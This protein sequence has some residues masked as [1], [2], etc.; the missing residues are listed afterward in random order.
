ME[1]AWFRINLALVLFLLSLDPFEIDY[2]KAL[3]PEWKMY[4]T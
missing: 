2:V 3:F 4:F 1:S